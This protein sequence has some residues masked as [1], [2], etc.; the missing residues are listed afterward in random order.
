M[1]AES[2]KTVKHRGEPMTMHRE[3]SAIKEKSTVCAGSDL[4]L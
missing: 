3:L 1:K 4:W 2:R